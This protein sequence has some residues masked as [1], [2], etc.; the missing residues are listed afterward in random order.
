MEGG[1]EKD[2]VL[3]V[4]HCQP[5]LEDSSE[6][7]SREEIQQQIQEEEFLRHWGQVAN[8]NRSQVGTGW[9]LGQMNWELPIYTVQLG[10]FWIK[11]SVK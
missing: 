4:D 10:S 11:I 1:K 6:G 5:S 3:S 9:D 2:R 7:D 8:K